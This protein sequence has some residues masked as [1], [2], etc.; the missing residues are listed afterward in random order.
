MQDLLTRGIDENGQLRDRTT[1]KF[2][3]SPLGMIPDEWDVVTLG[4]CS[5][6]HNHL[7]KPI[8]A[9]VRAGMKGEY[10]YYGATGI[11]DY[12]NEYRING[13]YVLIGE[14]GD[15]FL[16]FLYQEMTILVEGKF[17]VSNHAHLL[18][19]SETCL[20]DWIHHYFCHGDITYFL[21]RQ[22]AGRFK[23][24]KATLLSLPIPLPSPTEQRTISD[25]LFKIK[26]FI[27]K[28]DQELTKL[29]KIKIGL[30]QDL[31][32]GKISVKPLLKNEP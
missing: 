5:E 7:R 27:G 25:C 18:K 11:V 24:N 3:R 20:T 29:K 8:S 17:N 31:L 10:P 23:L 30:M 19:G 14:D 22:G 28:F 26:S 4:D 9:T 15:H 12:L 21:T 16:K 13:K 1:H 32:T 6:L 2:K